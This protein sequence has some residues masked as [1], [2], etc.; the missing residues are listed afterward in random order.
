MAR[1]WKIYIPVRPKAVQ[2]VR[3]GSRG[4]YADHRVRKWKDTIRPY[5]QKACS[6]EPTSLPLCITQIRYEF[7]YPQSTPKNVRRFIESGGIVPYIGCADI[8]DNLAKGVVDTCAGLVFANDKQIW[9]TCDIMKVYK[10]E[11]G[12]YIEFLETPEVI[13]IDGKSSMPRESNSL[14]A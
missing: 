1:S 11:D 14:F 2:S 10:P 3:G 5:I 7:R 12:I 4:F 13:L 6:G 8:T 9:K